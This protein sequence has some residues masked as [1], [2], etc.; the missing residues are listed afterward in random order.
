MAHAYHFAQRVLVWLGEPDRKLCEWNPY[1]AFQLAR[2]L[3]VLRLRHYSRINYHDFESYEK[4]VLLD[5]P[6]RF[7]ACQRAL[8]VLFTRSWFQ[9]M[10]I[11]HEVTYKTSQIFMRRERD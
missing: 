4:G 10:W 3:E 6:Q 9:R 5:L 11:V 7:L 2:N 1:L 8:R